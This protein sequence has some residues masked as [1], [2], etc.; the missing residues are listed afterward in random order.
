MIIRDSITLLSL[1]LSVS[2]SLR[3]FFPTVSLEIL[4]DVPPLRGYSLRFYWTILS[5][6]SGGFV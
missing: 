1:Q 3:F 6:R 2:F 4:S 5:H